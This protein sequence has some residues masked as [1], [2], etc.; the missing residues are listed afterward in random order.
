[1][2]YDGAGVRPQPARLELAGRV[3]SDVARAEKL[4]WGWAFVPV[5]PL[6]LWG[7]YLLLALAARAT[8]RIGLGPLLANAVLAW[9][10]S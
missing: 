3:A 9:T 4:G 10:R 6:A 2:P 7:P 8:S 5:N 1:M